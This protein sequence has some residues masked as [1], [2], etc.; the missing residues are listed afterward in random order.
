[1]PGSAGEEPCWWWLQ[2]G[3]WGE[4][5][6]GCRL[7]RAE[8]TT[9]ANGHQQRMETGCS[10]LLKAKGWL[11]EGGQTGTLWAGQLVCPEP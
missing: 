11:G 9:E 8:V 6:N 3:E 5:S 2:R 1:M 4:G 7:C 10:W